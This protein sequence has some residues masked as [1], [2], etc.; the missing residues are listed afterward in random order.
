MKLRFDPAL[1]TVHPEQASW[2][3]MGEGPTA[4]LNLKLLGLDSGPSF[5]AQEPMPPSYEETVKRG[6]ESSGIL[7]WVDWTPQVIA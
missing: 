7:G 1:K 5:P 3:G 2:V 4:R 6:I